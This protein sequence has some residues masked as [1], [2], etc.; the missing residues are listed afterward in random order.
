MNK[1]HQ[2]QYY[3]SMATAT[4]VEQLIEHVMSSH[5]GEKAGTPVCIWGR[6]GIGKTELVEE[7]AKKRGYD[8]A[9]IAPAQFEEM[10]DL[11]GMPQIK[12]GQTIF[13]AP[14]WVPKQAG[15]GILLIDDVNR[16]D[17][18]ILRGIMQ[19]LQNHELVSWSL[20]KQWQ[21]I[22]TAN[23]DGG[24]YSVTPMDDAMLTRMLH[25]SMKF[26]EKEWANWALQ[27]NVDKRGINFV[28]MY[29]EIVTGE[30]STPR[31]LV[32]FFRSIAPIQDLSQ[33]IE[34]V[35]IL[36]EASL[37]KSTTAT[38]I[39]F[40]RQGMDRLISPEEI[41]YSKD[42][43]QEVASKIQPFTE[44]QTLKI[45]VISVLVTRLSNYLNSNNIVLNNNNL[46]N[47]K[48]FLLLDYIP[49]D[50][51]FTAIQDMTFSANPQIKTLLADPDIGRVL[52]SG[53]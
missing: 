2:Y 13:A 43:E 29:P 26:D 8:W 20:P 23:P 37:D 47:I 34:L 28:L 51:R 39:N 46:Q 38:F 41:V 33:Q 40:I 5:Q 31:T 36:A 48:S 21:I 15:P 50:I 24:D 6:H 53:M 14:E 19:L 25:I 18:R 45:D 9:Y 17:I 22:L 3:G 4:Q 32:Q 1:K 44:Q 42:F 11:L 7:F 35:Q 30:R 10:G 49:N 12:D 27:K 52:I 16:A